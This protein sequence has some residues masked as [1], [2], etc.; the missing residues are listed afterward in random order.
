[1]TLAAAAV[2][3]VFAVALEPLFPLQLEVTPGIYVQLVGIAVAVGL[4]ASLVGIRRALTIDPAM[5][6]G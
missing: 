2:S 4:A 6:F 5:A 1:M 3:A